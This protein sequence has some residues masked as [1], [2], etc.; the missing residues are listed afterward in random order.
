MG[1]SNIN[2]TNPPAFG[3]FISGID[4]SGKTKH[5]QALIKQLSCRGFKIKYVWMRGIGKAFFSM[6]I[7]GL[8]RILGITKIHKLSNGN[9]VS[10]YHFYAYPS[11]RLL[12]PLFQLIDALLFTIFQVLLPLTFSTYVV[13]ERSPI[14]SFV[15]VVADVKKPVWF[16]MFQKSFLALIPKSSR[17]VLLDVDVEIAMR[18]K[19]DVISVGYLEV[20]RSLY[21][22]LHAI[23]GWPIISTEGDFTIV[24]QKLK[25][26]LFGNFDTIN[27]ME[28]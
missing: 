25:E 24:H 10:E 15:D 3:I 23:Y 19:E 22:S 28:S 21:K 16:T 8:C 13:V 5:V 7:L 20:R 2:D 14:D 17:V 9:N 4:G 27:F 12:W 6:P 26:V 18:R 1:L 11:L